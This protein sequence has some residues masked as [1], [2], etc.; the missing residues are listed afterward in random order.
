MSAP[1]T[2]FQTAKWM[3]VSVNYPIE[4]RPCK[5]EDME[6]MKITID[7][8]ITDF[9]GTSFDLAMLLP[10]EWRKKNP[11]F[12]QALDTH[13]M[14]KITREIVLKKTCSANSVDSGEIESE[15][16]AKTSLEYFYGENTSK[17]INYFV[18]D[19]P[20]SSYYI[21]NSISLE[22]HA[23]Y[24]CSVNLRLRYMVTTWTPYK[25]DSSAIVS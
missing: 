2:T 6:G 4:M 12:Q 8:N 25:R 13:I 14:Q 1:Q 24:T 23:N 17:V 3:R 22:D 18:G 10:A 16:L 19:I 11:N 21:I 9:S 7:G 15:I 5:I 20:N